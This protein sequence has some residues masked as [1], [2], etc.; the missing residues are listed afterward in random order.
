MREGTGI[1][2]GGMK[3]FFYISDVPTKI[4]NQ[5]GDQAFSA[6]AGLNKKGFQ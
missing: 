1:F 5:K 2:P 6:A 3:P 4:P